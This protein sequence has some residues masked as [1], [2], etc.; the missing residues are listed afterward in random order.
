MPPA[1]DEM[2][3]IVSSV[4]Q[5]GQK[6]IRCFSTISDVSL[7]YPIYLPYQM[8]LYHIR[9]IYHIS[10]LG[11]NGQQFKLGNLQL[12]IVDE[13]SMVDHKLLTCIY[14]TY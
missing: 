2:H 9:Y 8:F 5:H 4:Q 11:E 10:Q 3:D 7:P 14:G 1:C 13:I 6:H 12:L